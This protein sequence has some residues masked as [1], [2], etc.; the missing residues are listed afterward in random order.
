MSNDEFQTQA[1]IRLEYPYLT[2]NFKQKLASKINLC[3]QV[4]NFHQGVVHHVTNFLLSSSLLLVSTSSPFC[5][6]CHSLF[7]SCL[8]GHLV[9]AAVFSRNWYIATKERH[10]D[11]GWKMIRKRRIYMKRL[12][13]CVSWIMIRE[14]WNSR[15]FFGKKHR[16]DNRKLQ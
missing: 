7:Y 2:G 10:H 9:Q 8:C 14:L 4:V 5:S 13:S 1:V 12:H 3:R 6:S 11:G 15:Q 16:L